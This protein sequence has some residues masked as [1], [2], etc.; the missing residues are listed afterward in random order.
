MADAAL[1][2]VTLSQDPWDPGAGP[3]RLS[4][5][6]WSFDLS[7]RSGPNGP[8]L[9]GVY[10]LVVESRGGSPVQ[11]PLRV[12]GKASGK[13]AVVAGPQPLR[14]GDRWLSI[15]WRPMT[16]VELKVYSLD[17]SLVRDLGAQPVSPVVWD[18]RNGNGNEVAG[19]VYLLS[20]RIPGESSPQWRKITIGR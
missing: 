14:R 19:G 2:D 5:G 13:V 15:H 1:V 17:G 18:L 12:V 7:G 9:N 20:V 6:A 8:I 4:S 16:L 10:L 3:L 11:K